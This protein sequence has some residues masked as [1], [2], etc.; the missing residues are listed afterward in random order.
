MI[1]Y[2]IICLVV[3]HYTIINRY[4]SIIGIYYNAFLFSRISKCFQGTLIIRTSSFFLSINYTYFLIFLKLGR[5]ITRICAH[6]SF[7]RYL[8]FYLLTAYI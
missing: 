7:I 6:L 2:G 1:I 3:R 4:V 5:T 8:T